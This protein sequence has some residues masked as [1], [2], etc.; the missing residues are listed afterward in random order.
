MAQSSYTNRAKVLLIDEVDVFFNREFYGRC[1]SPAAILRH[2]DITRLLDLIWQNR[3][4]NWTLAQV[5]QSN[6]YK[7]CCNVLKGWDALLNEAIKDMLND[8]QKFAGHG[9]QVSNDKIGYKEQDSI[10]YNIRYGYKTLFAYYHEHEQNKISKE[11]LEKNK[12]LSFQIGSFS[13]AEVPKGFSCIM[14]VSGTLKTLSPPEQ[15]VVE[16]D[17]KICKHTYMPSLF[18]ENSFIFVEKNDIMIVKESD[19]FTTLKKEIDDRL[20]GKI[21][22]TKRAVLVFF[23]SKKHLVEFYESMHF[24]TYKDNAVVMTEDNSFEEKE[25]LIKRATTSGQVG[26]FTKSF[27][28]GTDFVCRDQIVASNGGAHVIQTFLSEELSEEVQ[29]KGRTARQGGSGSYSMVLCEKALERFLIN[30]PDVNNARSTGNFYP[31]LHQKRND[32]FKTQ[33]AENKKKTMYPRSRKCYVRETIGAEIR[34]LSRTVVLMDATGSMSHLL[35]KVKTTVGT[36]FSRIAQILEDKGASSNGFEM[37][38]VVYRNYNAPEDM[39]LQVSPWEVKPDNLRNFMEMIESDYGMG[40]EA[41]EVGLAYVNRESSKLPVSQIILIGDSPANTQYEVTEKRQKIRGEQYWKN[42]ALFSKPTYYENELQLLKQNHIIV[43]AYFVDDE[44]E[45]NFKEIADA[46]GG[47]C[48]KLDI[49]S[50]KGST[51]LTDLVAEEVLRNAG[52]DK[53]DELV[54]A[55]RAKFCFYSIHFVKLTRINY[56]FKSSKFV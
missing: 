45:T 25:S 22:G 19:Y 48:E 17:Y 56:F 28:R 14:G 4:A 20:I 7:A 35:Q 53:G 21:P 34:Q 55:Y 8:V 51:Q 27:G 2:G 50:P 32:F 13:Y 37:Q 38:F 26:L 10:C 11:S 16:K 36:M 42:T 15:T 49:N 46:T 54:K 6:E 24:V 31:M 23:E 47:R 44:A 5:E 33:Y 12:F 29:I 43:H 40:N 30:E 9:Y 18:G 1:Y 3:N 52:G 39:I 41:I